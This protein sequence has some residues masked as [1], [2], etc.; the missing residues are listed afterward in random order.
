MTEFNFTDTITKE[1]RGNAL[2]AGRT[3]IINLSKSYQTAHPEVELAW[4][5]QMIAKYLLD[6]EAC[7]EWYP[8]RENEESNLTMTAVNVGGVK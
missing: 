8:V 7:Q 3:L 1:V 6:A 4:Q 5:A 2:A